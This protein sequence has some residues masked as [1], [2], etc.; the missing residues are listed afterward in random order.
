MKDGHGS[1]KKGPNQGT[2]EY[3]SVPHRDNE[4]VIYKRIYTS[5]TSQ[6]T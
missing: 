1:G 5:L 3:G 6:I 2:E 4:V